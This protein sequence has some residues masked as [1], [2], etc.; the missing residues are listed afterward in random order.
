MFIF[1]SSLAFAQNSFT[2]QDRERMIRMEIKNDEANKTLQLQ[3]DLVNKRI[4]GLDKKSDATDKRIDTLST[5]I[6]KINDRL[7]AF[8]AILLSVLMGV[9]GVVF[10]D[11]RTL[12]KSIENKQRE[13]EDLIYK[14]KRIFEEIATGKPLT[15]ELLNQFRL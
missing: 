10:W 9:L 5:E 2:Q 15:P 13:L 14:H 6:S 1:Y 12:L 11:K 3:I 4:E 8:F 7:F